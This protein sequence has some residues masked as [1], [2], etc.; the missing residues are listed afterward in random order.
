MSVAPMAA[1]GA[2]NAN[3]EPPASGNGGIVRKTVAGQPSPLHPFGH[4][5]REERLMSTVAECEA[6]AL[7][8][9]N[10]MPSRS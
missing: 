1:M 9:I 8:E 10:P 6:A 7:I 5:T 4:A 3:V 2:R